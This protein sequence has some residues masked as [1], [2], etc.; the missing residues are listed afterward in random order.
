MKICG[1]FWSA[2]PWLTLDLARADLMIF[3]T[4][5]ESCDKASVYTLASDVI[6]I[7]FMIF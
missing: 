2:D 7:A 5:V 1:S 6:Y 4:S 3:P